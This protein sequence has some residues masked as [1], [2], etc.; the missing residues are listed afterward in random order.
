MAAGP[1]GSSSTAHSPLR[2]IIKSIWPPRSAAQRLA[3][4]QRLRGGFFAAGQ[5]EKRAMP[6]K[7]PASYVRIC[8]PGP[9]VGGISLPAN[10]KRKQPSSPGAAAAHSPAP[11][12][13]KA[14]HWP[15]WGHSWPKSRHSCAAQCEISQHTPGAGAQKSACRHIR[16]KSRRSRAVG[17]TPRTAQ[18]ASCS[19][20]W[21]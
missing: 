8:S 19:A 12:P 7:R 3:L 21:V 9:G 1:F 18:A 6:A 2:D 16:R 15:G 20:S 13:V 17:G 10:H 14:V 4:R 11:G 5:G